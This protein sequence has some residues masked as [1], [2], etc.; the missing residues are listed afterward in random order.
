MIM[1]NLKKRI[2]NNEDTVYAY[3]ARALCMC[4]APCACPDLQTQ[5]NKNFNRQNDSLNVI[6]NKANSGSKC[7]H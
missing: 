4:S 2:K 7:P 5:S 3:A 1:K 6:D